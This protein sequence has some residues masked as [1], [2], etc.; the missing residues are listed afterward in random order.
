MARSYEPDVEG[1]LTEARIDYLVRPQLEPFGL[2]RVTL[3]GP[4]LRL[5]PSRHCRLA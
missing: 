4:E 3:E 5:K 2:D 1:K